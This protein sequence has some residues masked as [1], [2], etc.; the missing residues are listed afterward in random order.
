M[1][2]ITLTMTAFGSYAEKTVVPFDQLQSQLYLITGDTGAGKTTIFDAITYALYG[3]TSGTAR[4][5]DL[6]SDFVEKS[7]DTVVELTFSQDGKEYTAKRTLHYS[8]PH[9]AGPGVYSS[10]PVTRATLSDPDRGPI[11]NES[12]VTARITELLG[13][14]AEQFRKIVMLAQGEFKKFLEAGSEE[15]NLILS[16]LFDTSAYVY[17]T[18]LLQGVKKALQEKRMGIKGRMD[19]SLKTLRL[20]E[21]LTEEERVHFLSED[22]NL[23]NSLKALVEEETSRLDSLTRTRDSLSERKSLLDTQ[24]GAAE[25]L[26]SQFNDLETQ[27]KRLDDLILQEEAMKARAAT[28]ETARKALHLVKPSMDEHERVRKLLTAT[29]KE[30]EKLEKKLAEHQAA[31]ETAQAVV[32]QDAGVQEELTSIQATLLTMGDQLE[33]YDEMDLRTKALAKSK[34]TVRKAAAEREGAEKTLSGTQARLEEIRPQL[35]SLAQADGQAVAAQNAE[36]EARKQLDAL[37]GPEGLKRN[38]EEIRQQLEDLTRKQKD[39]LKATEK[40]QQASAAR[41]EV[42]SRFILGQAAVLAGDLREKLKQNGQAVC[43]VCGTAHTLSDLPHLADVRQTAVPTREEVDKAAKAQ[44]TAEKR[45]AGAEADVSALSSGI[46]VRKETLLKNAQKLLPGCESFEQFAAPGC[47]ERAED[48]MLSLLREA[49]AARR[50]AQSRVETRNALQEERRHKET[51]LEETRK[52]LDRASQEENKATREA[53]S[54]EASLKEMH[55]QLKYENRKAAE[56]AM[57]ELHNQEATLQA[58]LNQHKKALEAAARQL[59]RTET[60]L[61]QTTESLAQQEEDLKGARLSLDAALARAGFAE[62]S[63]V[64]SALSPMGNT[65]GETWLM[66]EQQVQNHYEADCR[67]ARQHLAEL[68]EQLQDKTRPDLDSLKAERAQADALLREASQALEAH[69]QLMAN[70]TDTLGTVSECMESLAVTEPAWQRIA[71]LTSLA[72]G[73]TSEEGK[74]SFDRYIMRAF[75]KDILEA[76]N[77]RMDILSGGKYHLEHRLSGTRASSKSG[78]EI[79]VMDMSTGK[80]RDA[81]SLSGGESFFTSLSLALGLSDA[82]Q[83]QAGGKKLDA[84]FVDEGFGTLSDG[85]LDKALSVLSQLTEG[86]RLVGIISHVDKLGESIPQKILVSSTGHGSTLRIE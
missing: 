20:P 41:E 76:A 9:G 78:L 15:K 27:K 28:A 83:N 31:L 7:V 24:L 36:D 71:R 77:Y 12:R 30:K 70:H 2:P 86:N 42:Y 69:R 3:V 26:N 1:R 33:R 38:L 56:E 32:A 23:L 50:E 17:Y 52:Q 75:F 19:L 25:S 59:T 55:Q 57:V 66:Q 43:P 51:L 62:E 68:R 81:S 44:E 84:L 40:A 85:F 39:L 6:H 74:I 14:D 47:L 35:D 37:V 10:K 53:E 80:V 4:G 79:A 82:V 48:E 18:N 63:D 67:N 73:E 45:R 13:M 16:R 29:G 8:K 21:T 34:K 22:P 46:K 54:L 65:D 60:S 11:E 58:T 61:Q 5:K 72:V 64:L 49:E